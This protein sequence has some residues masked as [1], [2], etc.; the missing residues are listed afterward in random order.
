MTMVSN[1]KKKILLI[2]QVRISKLQPIHYLT[3]TELTSGSIGLANFN[4]KKFLNHP[5]GV[6]CVQ[7][8]CFIQ[9]FLP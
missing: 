2:L 8:E 3:I 4:K 5:L 6:R 9:P 7:L 1:R